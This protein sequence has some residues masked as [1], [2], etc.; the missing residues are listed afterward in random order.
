MMSGEPLHVKTP[1]RDSM[2]LSK[3]AGTS[4]YLKMDSAQPSGSFK[5]R[6]IGHFCKRWAKQGCAHFV[7]SSAGNAGMAAVYSHVIQKLQL[8]GNLRTPLPS[9]VVIVCGGSNISLAQ[10]RALKEQLGMTNRLPK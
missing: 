4:V 10:L 3:M 8:E 7:C 6:G 5:I 2:A 1:I 9:L